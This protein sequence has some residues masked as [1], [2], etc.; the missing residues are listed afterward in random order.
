MSEHIRFDLSIPPG[1]QAAL[2]RALKTDQ[3]RVIEQLVQF[4]ART[5]NATMP[6]DKEMIFELIKTTFANVELADAEDTPR[7]QPPGS[8]SPSLWSTRRGQTA[9]V[10]PAKNHEDAV[11]VSARTGDSSALKA[12]PMDIFNRKLHNMLQ[13]SIAAFSWNV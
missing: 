9:K 8:A 13:R 2:V 10:E 5:A 6:R 3:H 4:D 12:D 7:A 11:D 1:Q